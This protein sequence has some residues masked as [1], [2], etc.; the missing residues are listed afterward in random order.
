[1]ATWELDAH[2]SVYDKRSLR[3]AIDGSSPGDVIVLA[4]GTYLLD[5]MNP[6]EAKKWLSIK[7]SLTIKADVPG[8]V[9]LFGRMKLDENTKNGAFFFVRN[10][11]AGF[12]FAM[13]D[14]AVNMGCVADTVNDGPQDCVKVQASKPGNG[15]TRAELRRCRFSNAGGGVTVETNTVGQGNKDDDLVVNIN[16]CIIEDMFD[17]RRAD[18][19]REPQAT[20]QGVYHNG[21]KLYMNNTIIRRVGWV[22]GS[23]K[24]ERSNKSHGLYSENGYRNIA[25][26]EAI[27]CSHSG[28]AFRAGETYSEGNT[29]TRCAVG[30]EAGHRQTP[31]KAK[32]YSFNDTVADGASI[33]QRLASGEVSNTITGGFTVDCPSFLNLSK[34]KAWNTNAENEGDWAGLHISSVNDRNGGKE[35]SELH[36]DTDTI[37]VSGWGNRPFRVSQWSE[38]HPGLQK[39]I[40][41]YGTGRAS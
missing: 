20:S 2:S 41:K 3:F 38:K 31:W 21:G 4:P 36:I 12:E 23:A 17:D 30:F 40:E 5:D 28:F 16:D 25:R 8:T 14:I 27:D 29:A 1:M 26:C 37:D 6:T 33:K 9:E 11:D 15:K 24:Y 7:H 39:L 10:Q 34:F 22:P 32:V 35:Q 13:H 18:G 19:V